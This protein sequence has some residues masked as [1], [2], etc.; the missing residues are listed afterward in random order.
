LKR[1]CLGIRMHSGWGLLVAVTENNGMPEILDRRRIVISDPAVPGSN[2]PYHHASRL[3]LPEAEIY[4]AHRAT[5]C[6]RLAMA[7]VGVS[8]RRLASRLYRI[9]AAAVLSSSARPLP[10]LANTLASHPLIHTAEGEFFRQAVRTA[11]ERSLLTVTAIRE[12]ELE[13]HAR[14]V[15]GDGTS[16]VQER[17]QALGKS[18]GP[19]WTKE[20]KNAALA[21]LLI[22]N[23][24]SGILPE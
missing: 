2:Q 3:A 17:I 9:V 12:R 11:C 6:E 4:L 15:F 18:I 13:A 8:I 5:E 22:L 10:P 23:R 1:G 7:E 14:A 16:R 19:P 21:A 24:K 20:H